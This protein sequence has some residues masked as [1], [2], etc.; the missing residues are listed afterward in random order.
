MTQPVDH[1]ARDG[2]GSHI[3]AGGVPEPEPVE[4]GFHVS[5]PIVLVVMA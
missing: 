2:G 1:V 5:R 4:L 3:I